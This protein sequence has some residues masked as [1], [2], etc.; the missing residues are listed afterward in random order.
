MKNVESIPTYPNFATFTLSSNVFIIYKL[1]ISSFTFPSNPDI[2]L[3][4]FRYMNL[5]IIT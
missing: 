1:L 5:P 4:N 2:A 3:Q